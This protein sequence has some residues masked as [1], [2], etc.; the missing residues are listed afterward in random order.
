MSYTITLLVLAI[1]TQEQGNSAWTTGVR[2]GVLFYSV[3]STSM[4]GATQIQAAT[5]TIP[6]SQPTLQQLLQQQSPSQQPYPSY[7]RPTS[8]T[9]SLMVKIIR[10]LACM[11]SSRGDVDGCMCISTR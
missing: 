1:Y 9:G 7:P 5:A 10:T 6:Y 4:G 8:C 2:D 11:W 3:R